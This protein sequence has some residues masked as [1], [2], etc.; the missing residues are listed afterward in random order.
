V[1]IVGNER[2][3]KVHGKAVTRISTVVGNDPS[4]TA[5][6]AEKGFLGEKDPVGS[7]GR[8]LMRA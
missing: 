6:S 2:N 7:S 8:K 3:A 5:H 4:S 1:P